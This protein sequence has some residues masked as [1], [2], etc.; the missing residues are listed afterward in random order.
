M[1]PV[2]VV[3]ITAVVMI[4]VELAQ[5]S[6]SMAEGGWLVESRRPVEPGS[7]RFCFP[8][9]HGAGSMVETEPAM[10]G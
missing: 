9:G 3:L 2:S 6:P 5:P 10:V 1:W 8:G 4:L 7:G